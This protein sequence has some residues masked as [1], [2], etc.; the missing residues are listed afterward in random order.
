MKKETS[1]LT[2]LKNYLKLW[3]GGRAQSST[4]QPYRAASFCGRSSQKMHHR[5]DSLLKEN[6][7]LNEEIRLLK[8]FIDREYDD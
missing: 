7:R 3:V 1:F 2:S 6:A 8:E 4:S 5:L